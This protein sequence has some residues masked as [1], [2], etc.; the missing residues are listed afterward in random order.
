M[1]YSYN[2]NS[3]KK[4][5]MEKNSYSAKNALD[6][7]EEEKAGLLKGARIIA[8]DDMVYNAFKNGIYITNAIELKKDRV[9]MK[10]KEINEYNYI[11]LANI[12]K[13]KIYDS[14]RGAED[15]GVE[16]FNTEFKRVGVSYEFDSAFLDS[17]KEEYIRDSLKYKEFGGAD[18]ET[19]GEN[20]GRLFLKSIVPIGKNS[21]Y[22]IEKPYGA[23]VVAEEINGEV[24]EKIKKRLNSEIIIVKD[25]EI[26]ISTIFNGSERVKG[27]FKDILRKRAKKH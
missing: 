24:I 15:K 19:I 18:I 25:K 12:S 20:K 16:L 22:F 23:V 11:K 7:I 14:N 1:F 8:A 9:E 4:N 6:M 13:S 17:G 3:N 5:F 2:F 10:T 26:L 21:K 27:N